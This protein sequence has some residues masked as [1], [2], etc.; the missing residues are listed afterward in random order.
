MRFL[1]HEHADITAAL[2]AQGMDHTTVLFV[3]RRGWLH[4]Q[5]PG[6]VD[7]FSFFRERRT[8]LTDGRWTDTTD[9]FIQ[10]NKRTT[11]TWE[12]VRVAFATWLAA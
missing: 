7:S 11:L 3:K 4:V 8:S 12:E 10:G 1:P 6:R 2:I 5:V 9:H